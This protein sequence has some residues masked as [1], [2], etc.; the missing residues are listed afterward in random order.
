M[1]VPLPGTRAREVVSALR[2]QLTRPLFKNALSLYGAQFAGYIV[3]LVTIPYLARVLLPAAF[4][5]LVFAQSFALWMALLVDYGFNLSATRDVARLRNAPNE[6]ARLVAG[7]MGAKALLGAA[8]M[9]VTLTAV[10]CIPAFGAHPKHVIFAGLFTLGQGLSPLWYH[11]GR[12]RMIGPVLTDTA[13]R[14]VPALSVFAFVHA[15]EHGWRVLAVQAIGSLAATITLAIWVYTSVKWERPTWRTTANALKSGWLLF[16]AQGSIS[17]YT[18]ANS[19]ILGLFA[20]PAAVGWYGGAEK[21]SK[22]VSGLLGPASRALYPRM[23]HLV[24][25]DSAQAR[26]LGLRSVAAMGAVGLA[27]G[28]GVFFGAPL[29]VRCLLGPA[30]EHASRLLSVLAL[31]L[32]CIALSNVFGI[33][34]M[35]PLG[36]DR[37]FNRI[38]VVAGFLGLLSALLASSIWGPIGMAW[39]VVGTEALVTGAT[40]QA[41]WRGGAFRPPTRSHSRFC[42]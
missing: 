38:F 4:G 42:P 14:L 28:A 21:I 39:V 26:S 18:A 17:L 1:A 13:G 12:E 16:V 35:L 8:S 32:P 25:T 23:S 15:P 2:L 6:L 40:F 19:F 30:Y 34:W 37:A 5:M 20:P 31:A 11:Q 33:Q 29:L 41:L 9:A 7:V 36:L 27:L 24:A 10:A 22:A 3:P